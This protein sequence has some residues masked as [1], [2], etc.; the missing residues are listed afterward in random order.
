MNLLPVSATANKGYDV[1]LSKDICRILDTEGK[2]VCC[3]VKQGN[4]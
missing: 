2:V 1:S 3:G 4:L